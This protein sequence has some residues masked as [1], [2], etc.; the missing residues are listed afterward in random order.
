[1]MSQVKEPRVLLPRYDRSTDYFTVH[2][3]RA[4]SG[5]ASADGGL[6]NGRA[7]TVACEKQISKRDELGKLEPFLKP[8][9]IHH[10]LFTSSGDV[11]PTHVLFLRVLQHDSRHSE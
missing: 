11:L 10:G 6:W 4:A 8:S 1:M 5:A 3:R 7:W 2:K 9:N